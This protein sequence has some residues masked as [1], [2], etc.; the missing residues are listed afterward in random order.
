MRTSKERARL[1]HRRTSEIKQERRI[2]RQR[3]LDAVVHGGL[4]VFGDRHRRADAGI[5][6]KHSGRRGS[7]TLRGRQVCSEAMLHWAIS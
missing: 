4:P 3:R 2:K 6:E 5:D 7:P 1:I